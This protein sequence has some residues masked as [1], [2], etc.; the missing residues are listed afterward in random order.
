MSEVGG[1]ELEVNL[2]D[3]NRPFIGQ[4]T[5]VVPAVALFAIKSG[6]NVLP[7]GFG[8]GLMPGSLTGGAD[9]GDVAEAL[10]FAAVAAV[11]Q[12]IVIIHRPLRISWRT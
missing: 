10:Q 12:F 5:A 9:K 2:C 7:D 1:G 4:I 11:D 3:V 6:G 8:K